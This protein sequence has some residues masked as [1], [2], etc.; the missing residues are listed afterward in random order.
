M[1]LV[2]FPNSLSSSIHRD[3]FSPSMQRRLET[4][5]GIIVESEKEA[6]QFLKAF[7]F[8]RGRTFRDIPLKLLNEHS[9]YNA[10]FLEPMLKG[11]AWGLVSDGG[12]P[13]IAD[14]GSELVFQARAKG[15]EIEVFPG[16]CSILQALLLSGFSAQ[17]FAFHGYFPKEW[18]DLRQ[19]LQS[20]IKQPMTHIFIEA[21][22]RSLKLLK[23]L[24]LML[25]DY[26][27]LSVACD[28]MMP[29]Q[30]VLTHSITH[31]KRMPLPNI[32][33]K[34]CVFCLRGII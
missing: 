17:S 29:T 25:P 32:H 27:Y 26:A 20:L 6:R 24:L 28:L 3:E 23:E 22:Y 1:T 34:P 19:K 5:D 2:L 16:P 14:P 21:P 30:I 12:L 33:K 15:I 7:S 9:M 31:W 11:E 4:V 13:C 18:V 10:S 8:D